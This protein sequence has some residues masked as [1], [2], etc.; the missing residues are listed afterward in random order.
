MKDTTLPAAVGAR[1]E[2]GVGRLEPERATVGDVV[3]VD[4]RH[5][6]PQTLRLTLE[7]QAAADKANELLTLE[8]KVWRLEKR[9]FPP[10]ATVNRYCRAGMCLTTDAEHEQWCKRHEPP[11]YK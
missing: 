7:T 10:P 9:V 6:H 8:P 4:V 11:N 1:I 5:P 3:A 2:P